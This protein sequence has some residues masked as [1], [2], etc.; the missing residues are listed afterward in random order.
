[1]GAFAYTHLFEA[2]FVAPPRPPPQ[3]FAG[4]QPRLIARET[5][6]QAPLA[7]P[8]SKRSKGEPAL[9]PLIKIR[10]NDFGSV[11]EESPR[12]TYGFNREVLSALRAAM[13]GASDIPA[14]FFHQPRERVLRRAPRDFD[15]TQVLTEANQFGMNVDSVQC[16]V[17][18]GQALDKVP[19]L[20]TSLQRYSVSLRILVLSGCGLAKLETVDLPNLRLFDVTDNLV[21]K[22][23]H[24]LAFLKGCPGL[25]ELDFRGNPIKDILGLIE[26]VTGTMASIESVNGA[27]VE[28]ETRVRCVE[29]HHKR[30]KTAAPNVRWE[31]TLVSL[32]GVAESARWEPQTLRKLLLPKCNLTVFH[33]KPFVNLETLDL[34]N[35]AISSVTESGIAFCEALRVCDLRNNAIAKREQLV[36]FQFNW[37]L[38]QL[39]LAGNDVA[40]LKEYRSIVIS[41]TRACVGNNRAPGLLELDGVEV[42]L[43]ER[44]SAIEMHATSKQ[45]L[46]MDGLRWQLTAIEFFGRAQLAQAPECAKYCIMPDRQLTV[47]QLE[48]LVNLRVVDLSRNNLTSVAGLDQLR[49][50]VYVDFSNNPKLN[51]AQVLQQLSCTTLLQ[52]MFFDESKNHARGDPTKPAYRNQILNALLM[53]NPHLNYVDE[54][55]VSPMERVETYSRTGGSA[56]EV[57]QYKFNLACALQVMKLPRVLHPAALDPEKKPYKYES[58]TSLTAFGELGLTVANFAAFSALKELS[59]RNNK[60]S[61]LLEMGLQRLSNLRKLDLSNNLIRTSLPMVAAFLDDMPSLRLVA[62]AGNPCMKTADDRA[63]LIGLMRTM[64]LDSPPLHVVDTAVTVRERVGVLVQCGAMTAEEGDNLR[65]RAIA[66]SCI[67]LEV[68][69]DQVT[70]LDFSNTGLKAAGLAKYVNLKVL[71]LRG[72]EFRSLHSVQ[73]LEE[74]QRLEVLD[75]RN[76]LLTNLGEI[77]R[78]LTTRLVAL[79]AVGLAG[80]KLRKDYRAHLLAELRHLHLRKSPL[81]TIDDEEITPAELFTAAQAAGTTKMVKDL[82]QFRFDIA[83]IRRSPEVPNRA[84]ISELDLSS[85]GLELLNLDL[86][87]NLK[88]LSLANNSLNGKTLVASQVATLKHL[89]FLNLANNKVKNMDTLVEVV[90]PLAEL[91]DLNFLGNACCGSLSRVDMC[92]RF[93]RLSDPMCNLEY[94]ND[95]ELTVEERVEIA[96]LQGRKDL[97]L[98]RLQFCVFQRRAAPEEVTSL[99]LSRCGLRTLGG[100][101]IFTRLV[102]L[103]L[104]NNGMSMFEKHVFAYMPGLRYLDLRDNDLLCSLAELTEALA[105][106]RALETLHVL[107]ALHDGSTARRNQY[108]VAVFEALPSCLKLDGHQRALAVLA[109]EEEG[110]DGS[111]RTTSE[112]KASSDKRK[113]KSVRRIRGGPESRKASSV[114]LG[115]SS[116]GLASG[117][118]SPAMGSPLVPRIPAVSVLHLSE[119]DSSDQQSSPSTSSSSGGR[120]K[121]TLMAAV[122]EPVSVGRTK[123]PGRDEK[124][125]TKKK[126]HS[127]TKSGGRRKDAD[128]LTTSGTASPTVKHRRSGS[129][130]ASKNE[131]TLGGATSTPVGTP[132]N[133]STSSLSIS[134]K[135]RA[136]LA[137]GTLASGQD[138]IRPKSPTSAASPVVSE[139][140]SQVASP[141]MSKRSAGAK[142][143]SSSQRR[144]SRGGKIGANSDEA[145]LSPPPAMRLEATALVEMLEREQ[146][147]KELEALQVE[148]GGRV[149]KSL[150]ESGTR[151]RAGSGAGDSEVD[152][153]VVNSAAEFLRSLDF[154]AAAGEGGKQNSDDE[155]AESDEAEWNDLSEPEEEDKPQ[156]ASR[157]DPKLILAELE[158]FRVGEG[159]EVEVEEEEDVESGRQE[160]A[161]SDALLDKFDLGT[162][163]GS[164]TA[165]GS[166]RGTDKGSLRG[167]SKGTFQTSQD[168]K[169]K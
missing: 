106:C 20:W 110:S 100:L 39:F 152:D 163:R 1:L 103:N 158:M 82:Q 153:Q 58:V 155:Y 85:V 6:S 72:N 168:S 129:T 98:F 45:G 53:S 23:S 113:R 136:V 9:P 167:E 25:Q 28:L 37:E 64:K 144:G 169:K 154:G 14:A 10:P 75:V 57:E 13:P 143:G 125:K 76:N 126:T 46:D 12:E 21:G 50:L 141:G 137:S 114:A 162:A 134:S 108:L 89:Q 7:L 34:S 80:N 71:L 60:L 160:G 31:W 47:A 92:K 63:K 69:A 11:G 77:S 102:T 43:E 139:P 73:G 130:G 49:S 16:I 55:L 149:L 150:K 99:D 164:S 111:L 66:L 56:E 161:K 29:A 142:R 54:I 26:K 101:Q 140:S 122:P 88:R 70:R 97:D 115:A 5:V 156:P 17:L 24:I 119:S 51:L 68:A 33:V 138:G 4:S 117:L 127:R 81:T 8:K 40:K 84:M 90:K 118:V 151:D 123:S 59:L 52:V 157:V 133:V 121:T 94:V 96:A 147:I 67:P 91:A 38:R 42:S 128:V 107:H 83:F 159:P 30:G 48:R 36:A 135:L 148:R 86:F 41:S 65:Y 87:P 104:A 165:R 145:L 32:S 27:A 112:R 44:C 74:M 116:S 79:E 61:D 95:A 109:E 105:A 15:T 62:L 146:T 78:L 93:E 166:L 120:A 19:K 35:N 3:V 132:P 124:D 131:D 18:K 2:P 22:E